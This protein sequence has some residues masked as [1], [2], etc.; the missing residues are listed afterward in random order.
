MLFWQLCGAPVACMSAEIVTARRR[1]E[2][3]EAGKGGRDLGSRWG[4]GKVRKESNAA[5]PAL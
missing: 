5:G 4:G 2:E 3:R 1:E